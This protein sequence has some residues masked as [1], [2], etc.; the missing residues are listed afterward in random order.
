MKV[1]SEKMMVWVFSFLYSRV[2]KRSCAPKFN[3]STAFCVAVP[4]YILSEA[5]I[6]VWCQ[7]T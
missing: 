6:L 5:V 1:I 2:V 4:N 3:I 7:K